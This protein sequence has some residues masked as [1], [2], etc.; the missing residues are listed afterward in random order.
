[1]KKTLARSAFYNVIYR[2]L[3]VVFPLISAAYVS[4]V[5][6]PEGI[7]RVAYG[8]NIVSY[9]VMFAA[10]GIPEYATREIARREGNADRLF[11]E[12]AVTGF[13]ST[14][15]CAVGY[16][17]LAAFQNQPDAVSMVL[18]LELLF[19][20]LD[21]D[22]FYQGRE[23]YGYIAARSLITKLLSLLLLVLFVR[24]SGDYV[25]YCL[26]L[27]L[28]TG[29]NHILNVFH[30]RKYVRLT[31]HG[32]DIRRHLAPVLTL[33]ISAVTAS[34]YCKVDITMLG[35]L[36]DE[37]AVAFYTNAHKVVNIVLTLAAAVSAAFLPRLS[38]AY[39]KDKP[40]YREDI[41]I[42]LKAVLLLAVPC[43]AGLVLVAEDLTAVLFGARFAPAAGTIQILAVLIIIKG[44][45]DLLCYQALIS[46]GQERRLI[47]SRLLAGMANIVL[48]VVLIPRWGH[49]GAAIASVI[50]ELVVNGTLLKT[51]LSIAKPQISRGFCVSL[52]TAAAAMAL[53]VISVQRAAGDD[54]VSLAASMA[55]GALVYFAALLLLKNEMLLSV[56]RMRRKGEGLYVHGN[57]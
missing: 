45:G 49:N 33:M 28:G 22:W 43:C 5:L 52:L 25:N 41:T 3:N 40:R 20:A 51:S 4:R 26:V 12:L 42:G 19:R 47:N 54:L 2:A 53:A 29:C 23:E 31:L 8:Q 9:F 56:I 24:D 13:L 16:Y 14:A 7:G 18:G 17:A 21:I 27:C 11:S 50:S 30:A 46:A 44:V 55:V 35:W 38:Q 32:L 57:K 36:G 37:T 1:M 10:L 39:E 6:T 15:V 48:N 34:L